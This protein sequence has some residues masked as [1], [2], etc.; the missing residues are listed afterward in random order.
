MFINLARHLERS[1]LNPRP[2]ITFNTYHT[3]NKSSPEKE[4]SIHDKAVLDT[5]PL[6]LKPQG[7]AFGQL[8]VLRLSCLSFFRLSD[9]RYY[10]LVSVLL[11][12][13]KHKMS[14]ARRLIMNLKTSVTTFEGTDP[15]TTMHFI[16][17]FVKNA[18]WNKFWRPKPS[19]QFRVFKRESPWQFFWSKE[20]PFR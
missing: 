5:I 7:P 15:V 20:R 16:S 4:V 2:K 8:E 6:P 13:Q 1:N 18:I 9:Y 12:R 19:F 10:R 17:R 11:R 3:S 14:P